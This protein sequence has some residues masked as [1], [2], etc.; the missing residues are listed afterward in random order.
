[1]QEHMLRIKKRNF[2]IFEHI[3]KSF[4]I[5]SLNVRRF[6]DEITKNEFKKSYE[7]ALET[8]VRML[9]EREF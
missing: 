3:W 2:Y 7:I 5:V 9:L 4:E 6:K 1:M 8:L